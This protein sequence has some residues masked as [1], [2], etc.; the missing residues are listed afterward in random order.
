MRQLFNIKIG[1]QGGELA[2]TDPHGN[3]QWREYIHFPKE[4]LLPYK[5]KI[6]HHL[7]CKNN[8]ETIYSSYEQTQQLIFT[9]LW[10]RMILKK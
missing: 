4:H 10:T 8:I 5:L 3:V 1:F 6:I 7:A 2:L 9:E